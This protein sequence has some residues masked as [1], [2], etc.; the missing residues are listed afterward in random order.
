MRPRLQVLEP[1]LPGRIVDEALTVLE[2]TGVLIEDPHA[3]ER[4]AKAGIHAD[5]ES[6]RVTFPRAIVEQ[7][8]KDAPSSITFT[9]A[10]ELLT[11]PSKATGSISC[12]RVR[13]CASSTARPRSIASPG[14][15][16]SSNT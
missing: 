14:P 15:P 8:I 5:K 16:T 9:I 10:R 6:G 13:L 2:R 1:D 11:R 12:P 3:L 7:A 4:L